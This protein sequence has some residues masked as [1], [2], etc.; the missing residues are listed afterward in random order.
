MDTVDELWRSLLRSSS[1]T[2]WP[3]LRVAPGASTP[4]TWT[5]WMSSW[6]QQLLAHSFHTM[7][8]V[9]PAVT[10]WVIDSSASNHT[11]SNIDNLNLYSTTSPH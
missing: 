2:G 11:T 6:D 3:D 4:V 1:A 5:P 8:M 7:R 10:D 9:P